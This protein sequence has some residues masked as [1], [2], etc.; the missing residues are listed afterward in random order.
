[1]AC[2]NNRR[3][4]SASTAAEQDAC[5][6]QWNQLVHDAKREQPGEDLVGRKASRETDHDDCIEYAKAAGDMTDQPG[7]ESQNVHRQ[8]VRIPDGRG[9]R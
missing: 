9:M 8:N 4:A 6:N 3:A 7:H 5:A 2:A 1:M